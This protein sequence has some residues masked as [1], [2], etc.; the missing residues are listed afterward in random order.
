MDAVNILLKIY[1]VVSWPFMKI[2]EVDE[3]INIFIEPIAREFADEASSRFKKSRIVYHV[4][5]G[6]MWM[7]LRFAFTLPLIIPSSLLIVYFYA[8]FLANHLLAS[9]VYA[10]HHLFFEVKA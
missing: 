2:G 1:N 9:N 6:L 8:Y 5:Y 7:I 4:S 10:T 3:K